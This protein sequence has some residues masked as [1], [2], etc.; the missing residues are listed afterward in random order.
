MKEWTRCQEFYDSIVFIDYQ[1]VYAYIHWHT[2]LRSGFHQNSTESHLLISDA[3]IS[4]SSNTRLIRKL[5]LQ[6]SMRVFNKDN[7]Q[8]MG[9]HITGPDRGCTTQVICTIS[10]VSVDYCALIRQGRVLSTTMLLSSSSLVLALNRPT[11]LSFT[12]S[13]IGL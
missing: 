8:I 5:E 10:S 2:I 12:Q 11:T 6:L 4:R 7:L 9:L 1:I 13:R 3:P